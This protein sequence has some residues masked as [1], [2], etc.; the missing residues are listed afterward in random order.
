MEG[1]DLSG[2]N[3]NAEAP[4]SCALKLAVNYRISAHHQDQHFLIVLYMIFV[5]IY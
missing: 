2:R 4:K 5:S 1:E 3:R